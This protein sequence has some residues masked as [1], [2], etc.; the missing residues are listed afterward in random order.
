MA[1]NVF[2]VRAMERKRLADA[3]GV[4]HLKPI[5]FRTMAV[6]FDYHKHH[7]M[8]SSYKEIADLLGLHS[9][10]PIHNRLST[11][12]HLGAIQLPAGNS[13]AMTITCDM[14]VLDIPY[15]A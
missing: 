10:S 4:V 13:R 2:L 8:N 11:L 1:N 6:I 15:E 5:Y 12:Q 7:G 14:I 3:A 9:T